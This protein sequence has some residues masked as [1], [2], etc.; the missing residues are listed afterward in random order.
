[1]RTKLPEPPDEDRVDRRTLPRE[2]PWLSKPRPSRRTGAT[3]P[4]A[5]P[6]ARVSDFP[7]LTLR[8][9]RLT[10]DKLTALAELQ[11]VTLGT[12]LAVAV[13]GYLDAQDTETTAQVDRVARR[14]QARRLAVSRKDKP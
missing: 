10:A 2:R 3:V 9:P 12:L 4:G 13:T 6:H 14:V 11:G 5:K 1:M 7:K 8:V